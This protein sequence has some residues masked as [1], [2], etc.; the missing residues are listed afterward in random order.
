MKKEAFG[1]CV[2]G[3][4]LLRKEVRAGAERKKRDDKKQTVVEPGGGGSG[5]ERKF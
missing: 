5:N 2:C 3:K 4:E 1:L